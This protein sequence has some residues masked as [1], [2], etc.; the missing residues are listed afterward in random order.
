MR[1]RFVLNSCL[2]VLFFFFVMTW[3]MLLLIFVPILILWEIYTVRTS[4]VSV[5]NDHLAFAGTAAFMIG[6]SLVIPA[7]RLIYR[8]L[9]WLFA[10]VKMFF[11]NLII[12]SV[13][14][15]ILNYGYEVQN[16]DRHKLF[17]ILMIVQIVVC[18]LAMSVYFHRRP[19]KPWGRE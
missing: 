2:A 7:F 17:F 4:G 18:R 9:P 19:E 13:A 14:L 1:W 6:I 10:Y 15:L 5:T 16:S 8:A 11:L 12:L 3:L